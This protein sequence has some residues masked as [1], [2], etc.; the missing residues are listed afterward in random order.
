MAIFNPNDLYFI[1]KMYH[2]T[3]DRQLRKL[4]AK[5][6]SNAHNFEELCALI[7]DTYTQYDKD[8]HLIERAMRLSSE[9]LYAANAK[10]KQEFEEKLIAQTIIKE[11]EQ[12]LSAINENVSEAIFR[13]AEDYNLLFVNKGFIELF[14]FASEQDA[15]NCSFATL[16]KNKEIQFHLS[17]KILLNGKIEREEILCHR[18]DNS[19]FWGLINIVSIRN[20]DGTRIYDGTIIDITTQKNNENELNKINQELDRLVYSIGHD[21]RA[22]IASALGLLDLSQ[23][24]TD[25]NVIKQYNDMMRKSLTRLDHFI[26]DTLDYSR[27]V[28]MP[29]EVSEIDIE[30]ELTDIKEL[31]FLSAELKDIKVNIEIQGDKLC[32]TDKSRFNVIVSNLLSN[33]LRYHDKHKTDKYIDISLLSHTDKIYLTIADNGQ[34][35]EKKHIDHIFDLFYR[36]NA[37]VRGTGLGLYIVKEAINKL[38]GEVCVKSEVGKGTIFVVNIPNQK[39][40]YFEN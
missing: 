13:I 6:L 14:G 36:A 20:A 29:I 35:I 15:M 28:R 1:E 26:Q 19:V 2:R 8:I 37:S 27:N 25:V 4:H 9:E 24:E 31:L 33:A 3:L 21:L 10:A 30:K 22:P 38:S 32:Y 16:C 17:E 11:K 5:G 23:D 39:I 34:G 7:S 18:I 12:M 40:H